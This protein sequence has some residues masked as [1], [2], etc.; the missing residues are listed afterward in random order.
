MIDIQVATNLSLEMKLTEMQEIR[1]Y[2][3]SVIA[4]LQ[5]SSND[6]FQKVN[7]QN[8][9]GQRTTHFCIQRDILLWIFI[10][11][12]EVRK[13]EPSCNPN[14]W[15]LGRIFNNVSSRFLE[16]SNSYKSLVL[17]NNAFVVSI[18]VGHFL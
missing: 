11:F 13:I 16:T 10:L 6:R 18:T 7:T 9:K 8:K 4:T 3:I 1:L 5:F 17:I 14:N 12:Y 15:T 2:K